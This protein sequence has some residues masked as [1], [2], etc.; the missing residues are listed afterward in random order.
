VTSGPVVKVPWDALSEDALIGVIDDFIHREGTDY[1]HR[2]YELKDKRDS[3]RRQLIAGHAVI[4]YDSGTHS[5]SI[6]A[7][8]DLP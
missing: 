1:G 2:D 8:A 6:V 4:T 5:T 7:A 3:I